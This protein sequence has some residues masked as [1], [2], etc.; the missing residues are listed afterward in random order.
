M[1]QET[2]LLITMEKSKIDTGVRKL[3]GGWRFIPGD[4]VYNKRKMRIKHAPS[5]GQLLWVIDAFR[6]KQT[7][8]VT[9]KNQDGSFYA[10][11]IKNN[12]RHY[13]I[14]KIATCSKYYLCTNTIEMGDDLFK[15]IV[16]RGNSIQE[17][18]N[19]I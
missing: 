19:E 16:A 9:V 8:R 14:E 12:L 18:K 2:P 1:E 10:D 6:I 3:K 11:D 7:C 17:A 15:R 4:D 5:M 13:H